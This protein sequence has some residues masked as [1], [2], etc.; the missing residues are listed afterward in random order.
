MKNKNEYLAK[1]FINVDD[2]KD[3]NLYIKCLNYIDEIPYFK[4]IKTKTYTLLKLSEA[5]SVLE[6][7]CG[8]GNDV[9]RM[10][11]RLP[12]KGHIIGIDS[13]TFMIEKAQTNKMFKHGKNIQFSVEDGR[14]LPYS[15]FSFDRCRIDRTLQHI[16]NPDK[17]VSEV[18]RVLKPGGI[19]V[20]FDNDWSSFSLSLSDKRLSRIIENYWCDAFVNGRIGCQLK[21]FFVKAGFEVIGLYPSTLILDDFEVANRVY[22][23]EQT[24]KN[25]YSDG[26]LNSLEVENILQEC[27]IQTKERGFQCSLTSYTIIGDKVKDF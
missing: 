15:S 6:I 26:L 12:P 7:G 24:I 14:S 8:V 9:Y 5:T 2:A 18:Y 17:V 11:L 16:V 4:E 25:A 23:I 3:K 21:A 10:A 27:R 1:G 13:S 22:D 19:F 20:V